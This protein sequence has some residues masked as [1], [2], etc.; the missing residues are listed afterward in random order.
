MGLGRKTSPKGFGTM[1]KEK[2]MASKE[3]HIK[4]CFI[5]DHTKVHEVSELIQFNS[6]WHCS[7]RGR[8][9]ETTLGSK[10]C[11]LPCPSHPR[12]L[13]FRLFYMKGLKRRFHRFSKRKACKNTVICQDFCHIKWS[14]IFIKKKNTIGRH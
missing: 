10:K 12:K 14:P 13:C 6:S 1:S 3:L 2:Q 9:L 5:D 7:R 8:V 4:P 11:R